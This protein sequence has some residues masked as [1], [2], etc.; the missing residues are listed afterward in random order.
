MHPEAAA[1]QP[2][3]LGR[4]VEIGGGGNPTPGA[5]LSIDH[6]PGGQ[7]GTAGSQSGVMSMAG[8]C[9]DMT[10]LPLRKFAFDTLVARHVLEHHYDTFAVL[11]EWGNV[12][13]RVVVV[14]PDQEHFSGNTIHL[15]PTHRAAFTGGQLAALSR[16]AG[17]DTLVALET[18]VPS[19]SFMLVAERTVL[20]G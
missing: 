20:L 19:W 2:Y 8:V 6:T 5:M 15:D 1:V 10:Y 12:A 7:P 4:V 9:G 14:C 17:F 18:V 11:R 13:K 3:L 16:H